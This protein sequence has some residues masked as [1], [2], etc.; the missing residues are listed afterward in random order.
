MSADT[1]GRRLLGSMPPPRMEKHLRGIL[2]PSHRKARRAHRGT[3]VLGMS[4]RLSTRVFTDLSDTFHKECC[5]SQL[6]SEMGLRW[7]T[8]TA[9]LASARPSAMAR[10]VDVQFRERL[11]VTHGVYRWN[12]AGALSRVPY[13]ALCT[14]IAGRTHIATDLLA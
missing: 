3:P 9:G 12:V 2:N 1:S 6:D 13:A 11:S 14:R 5:D 7:V 8:S 4:R 10:A